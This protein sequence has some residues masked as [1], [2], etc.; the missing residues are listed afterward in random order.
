MGL[1][2]VRPSRGSWAFFVVIAVAAVTRRQWGRHEQQVIR[3][4]GPAVESARSLAT[5]LL[6][7]NTA[8]IL[9]DDGY[10]PAARGSTASGTPAPDPQRDLWQHRLASWLQIHAAGPLD[11]DWPARC[12]TPLDEL[13]QRLQ[14]SRQRTPALRESLGAVRSMLLETAQAETR[15]HGDPGPRE[16]LLG[17]VDDRT[18]NSLP[19]Q[20]ALL[21]SDVRALSLGTRDRWSP[22]P[23]R[24]EQYPMP[25]DPAVPRWHDVPADQEQ[26]VLA[27]PTVYFFRRVSDG[28]THRVDFDRHGPNEAEVGAAV[29]WRQPPRGGVLRASTEQGG[30]VVPMEPAT[31]VVD[32][33]D[34]PGVTR[35][36]ET[37][38]W[39][40]ATSTAGMAWLTRTQY[41]ASLRARRWD[42]PRGWSAPVSIGFPG[43][44]LGAVVA[45]EPLDDTRWR[46]TLL[47][48][49]GI[50][51]VVEQRVVSFPEGAAPTDTEGARPVP[52]TFPLLRQVLPCESDAVRYFALVGPAPTETQQPKVTPFAVVR[53]EG[54]VVRV[55]QRLLDG[56]WDDPPTLRCDA[57]R[58]LLVAAPSTMN[59]RAVVVTFP[60][61]DDPSDQVV[62]P[63][64]YDERSSRPREL[65]LVDDGVVAVAV[66]QAALRAWRWP[67]R[68]TRWEAGGFVATLSPAVRTARMVSSMR[69][70]SQG[71]SLAVW[72]E[73]ATVW[74][75]TE[76][77]P[78]TEQGGAA[79]TRDVEVHTPFRVLMSSEDGGWSFAG[80]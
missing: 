80:L 18:D 66:H 9:R 11:H 29:V 79:T 35:R 50:G 54:A 75:R 24:L 38:D 7:A 46:V 69:A 25:A 28:R 65:L 47:H 12:V 58:A 31:R 30:A 72:V 49:G 14:R 48:P 57:H 5:C 56:T 77:V 53:V 10:P 13:D 33:P 55:W 20:L 23:F 64:P 1:F 15:R 2:K 52:V 43:S 3:R 6:G 21:F 68:S 63:M 22:Q 78:A 36:G 76:S 8:W 61:A 41:S 37:F 59:G 34:E 32:L 62:P 26:T 19:H 17:R 16:E 73:G 67:L 74:H 44:Q 39:H 27:S 40:A 42:D 45:P 71:S 51:L 4:D 60:A 70:V